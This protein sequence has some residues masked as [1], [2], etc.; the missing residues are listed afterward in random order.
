MVCRRCGGGLWSVLSERGVED[1]AG[2]RRR[3]PLTIHLVRLVEIWLQVGQQPATSN[4]WTKLATLTPVSYHSCF[5]QIVIPNTIIIS[6]KLVLKNGPSTPSELRRYPT[7][8][9]AR[10]G[11]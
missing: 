5:C 8:H 7:L 11:A 3:P 6:L 4:A 1:G 10:Q 2:G 9:A